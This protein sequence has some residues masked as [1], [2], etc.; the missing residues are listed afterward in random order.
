MDAAIMQGRGR[1]GDQSYES[2]RRR[3][4]GA[5]CNCANQDADADAVISNFFSNSFFSVCLFFLPHFKMRPRISIRG[6]VRPSIGPSVR[7]S[8]PPP[9]KTHVSQLSG[10]DTVSRSQAVKQSKCENENNLGEKDKK[11]I[12]VNENLH[13]RITPLELKEEI[14]ANEVDMNY[15]VKVSN[16]FSPLLQLESSS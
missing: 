8:V 9:P 14:A 3:G 7:R 13:D 12:T 6:F 10:R 5:G 15:N 16:P 2:H 1:G 11:T 4:P